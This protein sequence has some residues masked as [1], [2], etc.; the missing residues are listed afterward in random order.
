VELDDG[1]PYDEPWGWMVPARHAL[2]ALLVEAADKT[3]TAWHSSLLLLEE[4][5]DCYRR[6][7]RRYPGN[8][9]ALQGLAN[10]L[11]RKMRCLTSSSEGG[12]GGGSGGGGGVDDSG[13]SC[14]GGGD[15]P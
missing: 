8:V 6:D 9:W 7:L 1:L 13:G 15:A 5:E 10:A 2:A 11:S 4:A 14:C 3:S 12:G